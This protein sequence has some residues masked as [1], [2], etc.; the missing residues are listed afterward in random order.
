L[1]DGYR[2]AWIKADLQNF[3]GPRRAVDESSGYFNT[4]LVTPPFYSQLDEAGRAIDR[5]PSGFC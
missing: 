5:K 3:D 1:I 2:R 4:I